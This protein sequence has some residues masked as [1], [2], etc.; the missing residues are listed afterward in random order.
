MTVKKALKTEFYI[1]NDHHN[2]KKITE[3]ICFSK[4]IIFKNTMGGKALIALPLRKYFFA[5][6]LNGQLGDLGVEFV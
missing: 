5:A 1:Y 4:I 2:I 3:K 6:S